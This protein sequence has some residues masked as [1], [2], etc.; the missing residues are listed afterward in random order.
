M[1]LLKGLAWGV[2]IEL[3][4]VGVFVAAELT[5]GTNYVWVLLALVAL[6]ALAFTFP[7]KDKR[8]SLHD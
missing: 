2:V 7:E 1:K 6:P 4:F 3:A 8:R 5:Q